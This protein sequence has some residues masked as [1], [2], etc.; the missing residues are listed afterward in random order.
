MDRITY[1]MCPHCEC[2]VELENELK[3]QKCPN[4]GKYIV[5]CS[6]CLNGSVGAKCTKDCCLEVLASINNN[7]YGRN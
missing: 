7:E 4:C 2:E 5:A 6:M 1:E 3:V